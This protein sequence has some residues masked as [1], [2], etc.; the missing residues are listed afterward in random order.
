[1]QHDGVAQPIVSPSLTYTHP[2]SVHAG[3]SHSAPH[4]LSFFDFK[5]CLN[6]WPTMYSAMRRRNVF[7][8]LSSRS[9]WSD[10]RSERGRPDK[11]RTKDRR[12]PPPWPKNA[13]FC[14]QLPCKGL[15]S[16]TP[17]NKV[18]QLVGQSPYMFVWEN[19]IDMTWWSRGWCLLPTHMM[20]HHRGAKLL[21]H[22]G[23]SRTWNLRLMNG[24]T[25]RT[26]MSISDNF[27]SNS[28]IGL[29]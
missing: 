26:W 16:F 12:F 11:A 13:M 8:P 25:I 3:S 21:W 22:W 17:I 7:V 24:H 6:I 4:V 5:R 10:A 18:E 15:G 27:Q 28:S 9:C 20:P 1:M 2:T 19:L 29:F 14:Y 23:H